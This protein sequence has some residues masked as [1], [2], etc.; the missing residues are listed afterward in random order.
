[1]LQFLRMKEVKSDV[2]IITK[3]QTFTVLLCYCVFNQ[4]A[5]GYQST[6]SFPVHLLFS[7]LNLKLFLNYQSTLRKTIRKWVRFLC[8]KLMEIVY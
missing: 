6:S 7:V 3:N 2:F 8:Q 4:D 1:M 5:Q